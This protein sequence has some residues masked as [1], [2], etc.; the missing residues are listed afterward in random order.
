MLDCWLTIGTITSIYCV[1]Y[2]SPRLDFWRLTVAI[3]MIIPFM[4]I[5]ITSFGP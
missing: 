3:L 5:P 1:M 2:R 4:K